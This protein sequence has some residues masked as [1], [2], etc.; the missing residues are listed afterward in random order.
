M[1]G[2]V[3]SPGPR[4]HIFLREAIGWTANRRRSVAARHRPGH[5]AG[6]GNPPRDPRLPTGLPVARRHRSLGHAGGRGRPPCGRK[7]ARPA[8]ARRREVARPAPPRAPGGVEPPLLSCAPWSKPARTSRSDRGESE[9]AAARGEAAAPSRAPAAAPGA[10]RPCRRGGPPPRPR[11]PKRRPYPA[12]SAVTARVPGLDRDTTS[13]TE[14]RFRSF[15]LRY[16]PKVGEVPVWSGPP[17]TAPRRAA[18]ARYTG[19]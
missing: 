7:G 14:R 8:H 5:R 12:T 16:F 1:H 9:S 3:N 2:P 6:S 13:D 17:Q 4:H 18:P 15:R 11:R 19:R 10:P